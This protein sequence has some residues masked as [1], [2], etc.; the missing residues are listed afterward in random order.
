MV[1]ICVATLSAKASIL[2]AANSCP[3][4]EKVIWSLFVVGTFLFCFD[5]AKCAV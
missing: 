2:L 3:S 5:E 1:L 4:E